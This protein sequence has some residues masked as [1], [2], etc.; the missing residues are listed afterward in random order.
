[1]ALCLGAPECVQQGSV[2][3][4]EHWVHA[5][6][7][8]VWGELGNRMLM[9]LLQLRCAGG[10]GFSQLGGSNV[11][12]HGPSALKQQIIGVLHAAQYMRSEWF[13]ER[14]ASSV[15]MCV[16]VRFMCKDGWAGLDSM[17]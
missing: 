3:V 10:W 8:R 4:S 11:M 12:G 7:L 9:A 2:L 15:G 6:A 1:M 13:M 16:L 17:R 5:T 14:G